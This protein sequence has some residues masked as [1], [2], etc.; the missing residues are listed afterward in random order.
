MSEFH[1]TV[2][3]LGPI[4]RHP[5]ADT[6]EVSVVKGYPVIF[7]ENQYKE[8]DKVVYIPVDALVPIADPRF[9]FLDE[10]DISKTHARVKGKKL[11][12]I[13]S[14]G[15]IIPAE[16]QWE[17]GQNVQVELGIE[18]WEPQ[19]NLGQEGVAEK[20]PGYC[21]IFTDI[22]S[23]RKHKDLLQTGESVVVTE[24]LHGS[25]FR[26]IFKDGRLWVGS[27]RQFKE[28]EKPNIFWLA[29][30][31]YGLEQK[32]SNF[33]GMA[34][35]GEVYGHQKKFPYDTDQSSIEDAIKLKIFDVFNTSKGKYLDWPDYIHFMMNAG[36]HG[37]GAPILYI[38]PWR[39]EL[40]KLRFGMTELGGKHIREGFVVKPEMER[41][42]HRCGRVCF[43][44]VSEDYLV[45]TGKL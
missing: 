23:L 22:E 24:K 13:Y 10:G 3:L 17:V 28:K 2:E 26:A 40:D 20:D 44:M 15:L 32:L 38:G 27:H 34:L 8:G 21:P 12:G 30:N 4:E 14:I 43:K 18:K 35:Y 33:E 39:P 45:T 41:Y 5:Q 7:K 19:L 31:K 42:E 29:A 36:L 37:M 6:L 1:P 11:R 9:A 25:N 16:P